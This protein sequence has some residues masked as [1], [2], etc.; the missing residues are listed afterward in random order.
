MNYSELKN[1]ADLYIK[2]WRDER[3]TCPPSKIPLLIALTFNS[4]YIEIAIKIAN[5]WMQKF[6]SPKIPDFS[7]YGGFTYLLNFGSTLHLFGESQD[8][9][10]N[11]ILKSKP[12]KDK[13]CKAQHQLLKF[14]MNKNYPKL[15][16]SGKQKN[17][18]FNNLHE[19]IGLI[20]IDTLYDFVLNT[21]NLGWHENVQTYF[22]L[23]SLLYFQSKG[24]TDNA[25]ITQKLKE[26]FLNQFV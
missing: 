3:E 24:I 16:I 1:N 9:L 7:T 15:S 26:D 2:D 14:Y 10:F 8:P 6:L 23:V 5:F 12:P 21:N 25:D 20:S 13:A 17:I 4:E 19:K 11:A 22:Q 18:S